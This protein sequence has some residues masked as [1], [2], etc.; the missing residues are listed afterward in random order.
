M[1]TM[2]VVAHNLSA[3]FTDRQLGITSDRKAKSTEKLSTGYKI[4]RAADD[5]S[6][7]SIS[8]KMRKKVR[9]LDQ[10][11]YYL[12]ETVSPEGYNLL[13]EAD[14]VTI[15]ATHTTE[16]TTD[17]VTYSSSTGATITDGTVDLTQDANAKQ[18]VATVQIINNSGSV[19]PSTGGI[20]TTIFYVIGAI[21]V[22][23]AG[24]LLVTRRRMNA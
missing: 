6:G 2:N 3:M 18:P 21:L 9:G 10:G 12:E 16:G 13:V 15:S 5:S 22:L 7:L 4:N 1:G 8:E 20:G 17:Q 11:T 14:A 19:L 24:I 23:G